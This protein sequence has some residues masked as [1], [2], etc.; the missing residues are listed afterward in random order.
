MEEQEEEVEQE[1][2]DQKAG[3]EETVKEEMMNQSDVMFLD[4][5]AHFRSQSRKPVRNSFFWQ[6]RSFPH[7]HVQ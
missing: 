5:L 2:E 7:L 1:E 3:E 6:Y 4:K